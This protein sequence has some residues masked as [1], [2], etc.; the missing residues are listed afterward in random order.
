MKI[1]IEALKDYSFLIDYYKLQKC[2]SY[3]E[4]HLKLLEYASLNSFVFLPYVK[5]SYFIL[6]F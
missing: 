5:K 2:C 1:K 6:I 3:F 4:K